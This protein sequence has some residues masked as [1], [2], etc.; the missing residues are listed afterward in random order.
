MRNESAQTRHSALHPPALAPTQRDIKS[1]NVFLN[2]SGI[3]KLGDVS[4][5]LAWR[6]AFRL[7]GG[8]GCLD[9]LLQPAAAI[10]CVSRRRATHFASSPS[11]RPK[12]NPSLANAARAA[13]SLACPR[14]SA[15][16]WR[17]RRRRWARLTTSALRSRRAASTATRCPLYRHTI[18][19]CHMMCVFLLASACSLMCCNPQKPRHKTRPRHTNTQTDVWSLGCVLYELAALRPP[20]E[21]PSLRAL[22]QKARACARR[23]CLLPSP[24]PPLPCRAAYAG[25]RRVRGVSPNHR[26]TN[27]RPNY[28]THGADHPRLVPAA[29]LLVQPRAALARGRAADS[30]RRA[31][32]VHRAGA[33]ACTR[34]AARVIAR[35]RLAAGRPRGGAAPSSARR[36]RCGHPAGRR[37]AL[38]PGLTAWG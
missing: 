3:L 37:P 14:C 36:P 12:P 11:L 6:S 18:S 30:R 34:S 13:R 24:P 33:R 28:A 8:F 25:G 17:S 10:D 7:F 31:A 2:S 22:I 5:Q 1:H 27:A 16:R 20:F 4:A 23:P 38:T 29:A 35:T 9:L 19:M 32:A 15:A 21:A 26:D